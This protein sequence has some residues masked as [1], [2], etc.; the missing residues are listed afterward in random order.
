MSI[1]KWERRDPVDGDERHRTL[2]K[3]WP[4][5]TKDYVWVRDQHQRVHRV[6]TTVLIWGRYVRHERWDQDKGRW[7]TTFEESVMDFLQRKLEG[8]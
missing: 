2:F 4:K 7:V 6:W 3:W 1:W 8:K 5:L